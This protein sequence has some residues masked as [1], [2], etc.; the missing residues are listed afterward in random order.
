MNTIRK[1]FGI[2]VALV[3]FAQLAVAGPDSSH[4]DWI[5]V[6]SIDWSMHT[7]GAST[8]LKDGQYKD[9][10]G[11]YIVVKRGKVVTRGW[12]YTKKEAVRGKANKRQDTQ[13]VQQPLNKSARPKRVKPKPQ[14]GIEPDEIDSK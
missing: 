6:M 10:K 8:N 12:D 5:D 14:E 11:R 13:Q 1:V 4:E 9:R 2:A 3:A 7:P